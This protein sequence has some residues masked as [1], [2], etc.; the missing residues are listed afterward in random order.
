[1]NK[2]MILKY[3]KLYNSLRLYLIIY[4]DLIKQI[5]LFVYYFLSLNITKKILI[6]ISGNISIL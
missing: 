2:I 3:I 5:N 4:D 1:M 6:D